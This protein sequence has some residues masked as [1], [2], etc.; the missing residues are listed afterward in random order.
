MG[1]LIRAFDWSESP[2]GA[3]VT[4]PEGLKTA[5]RLLLSTKHPLFIWWGPELIQLYNDAYRR[6]T[7]VERHPT[8]LG[9]PGRACWAE[10]WDIVG[11]QIELVMNG[12]GSTW[13]EN[14]L[15]PVTRNGQ[16]EDVFWTY[17]YT[18][19]VDVSAPN[20]VGGVLVLCAE[21]TE[22]VL[23]KRRIAGER[24]RL[25]ELFAR[26]PGFMALLTGPEH[27]FE[28]ANA[29]YMQLVG[30]R[31]ILGQTVNHVLP[32]AVSQGYID[33]LDEVFRSG[34][35]YSS[36]G[37]KFAAEILPGAPLLERYVD[38]V[39]QPITN[40]DGG[41]S[42]IFV[43]GSDV[44]E[45]VHAQAALLTLNNT[46]EQNVSAALAERKILA[47]VVESTDAL[48]QVLGLDFQ[49]LAL[50]KANADGFEKIYGVRPQVGDNLDTM[51][52]GFSEH[53]QQLKAHWARALAGEEFT[54][55][56]QLGNP[57][58]H[59]AFYEI[60]FNVLRDRDGI[61][62]GASSISTDVTEK[63]ENQRR[64][65][66]AEEKAHQIQRI[67]SLG[68]LTGG[69][70]HDFNNLLMILSAG[71]DMLDRQVEPA[72]REKIL[73]AMRHAVDRGAGLSR[74]LLAF[75]RRHPLSPKPI[76]LS[77]LVKN[78]RDLLDR[79]LQG[80]I[81]IRIDFPPELWPVEVDPGELELGVLNLAINARDAMPHGG[82]ITISAVNLEGIA[83]GDLN[84]DFVRLAL[85]DTG[86][87]IPPAV[88]G[89]VFEPFFTTKEVG[90]GSGLGLAQIYG[91][92]QA[93]GGGTRITSVQGQGTTVSLLLPRTLKT[94]T[95]YQPPGTLTNE[96]A[97]KGSL[98]VALVVEDEE[99]VAALTL[100]MFE[101]IGYATIHVN[102]ADSA[103]EVLA[104]G[105]TIDLVFS[106][107]MMPGPLKGTDLADEIRRL[108][109]DL[110]VVL[111]SGYAAAISANL[112]DK[113]IT[114]LPKPFRLSELATALSAAC[115]TGSTADR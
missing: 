64:L 74:Q 22:M 108:Y 103:L 72:R 113:Q 9:Q 91:F 70:A 59:R 71:L 15:V 81:S 50:N 38:F 37:A 16:R 73:A 86:T 82:A 30:K 95:K 47:E 13:H 32:S 39:F 24:K 19:I 63:L 26:A 3:P 94:P 18:P 23:S 97:V 42:G 31:D 55:I 54:A 40:S 76:Y 106:D 8:A 51:L 29:A 93:S 114:L 98:G 90:K 68:Q 102:R 35:A 20:G 4:W 66:E 88:L 101:Q 27:R 69:V 65:V 56:E 44:T 48:I 49:I 11:P 67:D 99:P 5:V 104:D 10:I 33:L 112:K 75:S 41:V 111:T 17:S 92:A 62:F 87:G 43:E 110:P 28:F 12:N 96:P 115:A 83:D 109:P 60:K 77:H 80:D 79:T 1:S 89:R 84:G 61:Q 78:M 34:R 14:Q 21:T 25:E 45:R 57:T 36:V 85:T 107:V 6:C 46:L 2:L 52:R 58:R 105:R 7:G 53:R 100:A